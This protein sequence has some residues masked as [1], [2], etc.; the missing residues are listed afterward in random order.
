LLPRRWPGRFCK[1]RCRL[2][3]EPQKCDQEPGLEEVAWRSIS[4]RVKVRGA[5]SRVLRAQCAAA[6]KMQYDLRS[7]RYLLGAL[8]GRVLMARDT[9][10][11]LRLG[12]LVVRDPVPRPNYIVKSHQPHPFPLREGKSPGLPSAST[13]EITSGT[14]GR[15]VAS[16]RRYVRI[17]STA[18]PSA[19][20]GH[21]APAGSR[22]HIRRR[23]V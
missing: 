16:R 22:R 1:R 17:R 5:V 3:T 18:V 4:A 23:D 2:C 7:R 10:V 9:L 13:L 6:R 19:G 8:K 11:S 14:R 20:I 15:G 21:S 12:R